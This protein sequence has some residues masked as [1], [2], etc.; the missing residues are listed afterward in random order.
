MAIFISY[1]LEKKDIDL[2]KTH[3]LDNYKD[4]TSLQRNECVKR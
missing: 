3:A 2:G 1:E 4:Y